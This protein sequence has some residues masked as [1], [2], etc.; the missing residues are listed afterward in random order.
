MNRSRLNVGDDRSCPR[1]CLRLNE[2]PVSNKG[3]V[4]TREM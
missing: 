2:R 4:S 3:L 1:S